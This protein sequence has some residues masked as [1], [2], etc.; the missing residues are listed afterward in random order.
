MINELIQIVDAKVDLP[1]LKRDHLLLEERE[2]VQ[3]PHG[4]VDQSESGIGR[5]DRVLHQHLHAVHDR[6][7]EKLLTCSKCLTSGLAVEPQVALLHE[8]AEPATDLGQDALSLFDRVGVAGD[9]A[10][11]HPARQSVAKLAVT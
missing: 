11:A 6:F 2:H 10:P 4:L 9:R 1:R 3:A 5:V 8:L 7:R